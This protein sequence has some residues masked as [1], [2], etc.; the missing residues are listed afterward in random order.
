[1]GVWVGH[2]SPWYDN[3]SKRIQ[4]FI[5]YIYPPKLVIQTSIITI[6]DEINVYFRDLKWFIAICSTVAS[7][8]RNKYFILLKLVESFIIY[9]LTVTAGMPVLSLS[10]WN[11]WFLTIKPQIV[12]CKLTPGS[13]IDLS[14]W[15]VRHCK[16]GQLDCCC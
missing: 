12:I 14:T 9:R 5:F 11:F 8:I 1:M 10:C 4:I 2:Q 7:D 16:S 3:Y 15:S 13:R 6:L